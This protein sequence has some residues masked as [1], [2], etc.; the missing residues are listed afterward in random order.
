MYT[1]ELTDKTSYNCTKISNEDIT[2]LELCIKTDKT[3][4]ELNDIF[5]NSKKTIKINGYENEILFTVFYGYSVL[6]KIILNTDETK[7]V[8]LMKAKTDVEKKLAELEANLVNNDNNIN[9]MVSASSQTAINLEEIEK[10]M[11]T[12]SESA[13]EAKKL[14][15]D[16]NVQV[17]ELSASIDYLLIMQEMQN[18][19]E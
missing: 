15:E 18:T 2:Y 6:S 3:C 7:T 19:E 1:V 13:A 10:S 5:S 16:T 14:A 12:T 4:E 8:V 11:N 17:S 9:N